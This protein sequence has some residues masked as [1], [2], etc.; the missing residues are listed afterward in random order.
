MG[1]VLSEGP[2][3][4]RTDVVLQFN[5]VAAKMAF[6]RKNQNIV[7][8][9]VEETPVP[10]T[11]QIRPFLL[12]MKLI[13]KFPATFRDTDPLFFKGVHYRCEVTRGTFVSFVTGL[14]I[15]C[16]FALGVLQGGS[17]GIQIFP[18]SNM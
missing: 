7:F 10:M 12:F 1:E 5:K 18:P 2:L 15:A 8:P 9:F 4:F 11:R 17:L 13:G 6:L 16:T 14:F 3:S